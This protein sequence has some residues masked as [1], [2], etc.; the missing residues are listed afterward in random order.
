MFSKI[1]TSFFWYFGL[2]IPQ[3]LRVDFLGDDF[4]WLILD[5][6]SDYIWWCHRKNERYFIWSL[7]VEGTNFLIVTIHRKWWKISC[8]CLQWILVVQISKQEFTMRSLKCKLQIQSRFF[9]FFFN[10]ILLL[11]KVLYYLCTHYNQ[12][13]NTMSAVSCGFG[14][15]YRRNP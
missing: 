7:I 14:H 5:K 15:I 3:I 9:I 4:S 2:N 8:I 6:T 10:V 12:S 13:G 11:F 1:L